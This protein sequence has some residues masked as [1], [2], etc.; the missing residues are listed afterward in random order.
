MPSD[1]TGIKRL[2]HWLVAFLD[3]DQSPIELESCRAVLAELQS[4]DAVAD[5]AQRILTD[6]G[7]DI[8]RLLTELEA[9]VSGLKKARNLINAK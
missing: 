9:A 4:L 8:Q 1:Q 3:R 5:V 2:E 6:D 7:N